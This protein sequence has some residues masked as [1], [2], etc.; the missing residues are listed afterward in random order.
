MNAFLK[1]LWNFR[2]EQKRMVVLSGRPVI[3][4]SLFIFIRNSLSLAF[5]CAI[6]LKWLMSRDLERRPDAVFTFGV[7]AMF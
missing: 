2:P 3:W 6:F 1:I 5:L 7:R 4:S